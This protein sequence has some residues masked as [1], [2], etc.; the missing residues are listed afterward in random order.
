MKAL[1]TFYRAWHGRLHFKGAG[2]LIRTL[3]PHVRSLQAC[4]LPMPGAG[5]A[6]LDFRDLQAFA[7]LN[8]S[9]GD[10][11]PNAIL[12][13]L[14]ARCAGP[15]AVIWDIG[16]SVGVVSY[17]LATAG[18]NAA[19]IHA[20]EPHPQALAMLR[21]LFAGHGHVHVHPFGLGAEA[22]ELKLALVGGDSSL[23]TVAGS[24]A[25]QEQVTVRVITGDDVV[26]KQTA[27]PPRVIKIDVEGFEAQVLQGLRR[28][29]EFHK[30][31]IFFE[32]I[33]L[34]DDQLRAMTP[35]GYSMSFIGSD[36]RLTDDSKTR[37][38]GG[39]AVM[40][41]PGGRPSLEE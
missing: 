21:S 22:G 39:D 7:L 37:G 33:F 16:A 4:P 3:A 8:L 9:L 18:L 24:R 29:V 40:I 36:G 10:P 6:L 32:H 12:I 31:Y 28:T 34:T 41:P 30:P 27:P 11:G 5:V 35:E 19:E 38:G 17:K 2:W 15:G 1:L 14:I 26:S 20:F 23:S 13:E 25:G